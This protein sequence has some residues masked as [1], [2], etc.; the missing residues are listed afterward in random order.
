MAVRNSRPRRRCKNRIALNA[1]WLGTDRDTGQADG[2]M[3]HKPFRKNDR[4]IREGDQ[5]DARLSSTTLL[6]G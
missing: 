6:S 5:G 1:Q 3:A 4:F 2:P